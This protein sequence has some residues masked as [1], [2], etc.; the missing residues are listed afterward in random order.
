MYDNVCIMFNFYFVKQGSFQDT[1]MNFKKY[2]KSS[3]KKISPKEQQEQSNWTLGDK[4]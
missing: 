1:K 4:K 2:K 3:F